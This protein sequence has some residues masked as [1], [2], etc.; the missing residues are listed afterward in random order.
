MSNVNRSTTTR[1]RVTACLWLVVCIVAI[2]F[3]ARI[4][5]QRELTTDL[6]G[7]LPSQNQS[8]EKNHARREILLAAQHELLIMAGVDQADQNTLLATFS[9]VKNEWLKTQSENLTEIP[10]ESNVSSLNIDSAACLSIADEKWLRHASDDELLA[11]ALSQLS[12]F[13]QGLVPFA[14]DPLGLFNGWLQER[15]AQSPLRPQGEFL[16]TEHEGRFWALWRIRVTSDIAMNSPLYEAVD[17]LK[18]QLKA[19]LPNATIVAT[20]VPLFTNV[21]ATTAQQELN[22]IG[23][24]S[25]IG[26]LLLAWYWFSNL[27]TMAAIGF[28][29]VNA[30]AIALAA[31]YLLCGEVHLITLV[32]G[33]SLIGITV[34]YSAHYFCRRYGLSTQ[35]KAS[36]LGE[37]RSTLA[38]ALFSTSIAF[39][40]MALTPLPGLH[41]MALFCVSGLLATFI[42]VFVWLPLIDE[43][44]SRVPPHIPQ[45]ERLF[46]R[47]PTYKQLF[48]KQPIV[49]KVL[50]LLILIATAFGLT[51]LE[52][53]ANIRDLNHFPTALLKE[54]AQIQT[55]SRNPSTS[56][57][58]IVTGVSLDD[59]LQ[60]EERLKKQLHQNPIEGISLI[61][62][63]DWIAS[64]ARQ[65][66]IIKLKQSVIE[67]LNPSLESMLGARLPAL[68]V[69]TPDIQSFLESPAGEMFKA[70]VFTIDGQWYSVVSIVGLN[71]QNLAD[72]SR[73]SET[74]EGIEWVDTTQELSE[75]LSRYRD[76]VIVFLTA[77]LG[78]IV[79]VLTCRFDKNAWRAYLP[80]IAG[81]LL[82]GAILGY[83]GHG[84]SLFT[85]LA[86]ILLLGLGIDY[87]IFLT[88]Y[89]NDHR[90]LVAVTFAA[91][92][93]FLSFGVLALS[94]TPALHTFGLAIAIGQCLIWI[95]TP[96]FRKENPK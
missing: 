30:L 90:T 87:G 51:R 22:L 82:T 75:V 43:H 36:A 45:L 77:G 37:L 83:C 68:S 12:G 63:S 89:P 79:V 67:R 54:A 15:A 95:L 10:V 80:T 66:A 94:Q 2:L 85:V 11:R 8:V 59:V 39:G 91:F 35:E 40:V 13:G 29:T 31:T 4:F 88:S 86:G 42:S 33:M 55:V 25:A 6:F 17:T 76:L 5:I 81:L 18:T 26:V 57:Y 44:A 84:V 56:Q 92:T 24:F 73:L 14:Q 23:T 78:L 1:S 9:G 93:T 52:F 96:L 74:I 70:R 53:S 28:I 49:G 16:T 58:F 71:V 32:F 47:V 60:Q 20:G 34:D 7:L 61:A 46:A 50:V 72:V 3:D 38:L 27:K 62:L 65:E 69:R 41:Q 48:A 21:A 64:A 19:A